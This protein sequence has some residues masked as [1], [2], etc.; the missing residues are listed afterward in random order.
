MCNVHPLGLI[1]SRRESGGEAGGGEKKLLC[2]ET[3]D[4]QRNVVM[5]AIL[6]EGSNGSPGLKHMKIFGSTRE[7][8]LHPLFTQEPAAAAPAPASRGASARIFLNTR[9][10]MPAVYLNTL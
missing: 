3:R 9:C 4:C 8:L 2:E 1:C 6:S 5:H 7:P 10:S